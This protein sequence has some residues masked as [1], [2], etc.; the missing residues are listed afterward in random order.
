MKT[1]MVDKNDDTNVVVLNVAE[2]ILIVVV[3]K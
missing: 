2:L 1:F 3:W